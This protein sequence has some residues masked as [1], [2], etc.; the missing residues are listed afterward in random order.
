MYTH[1]YPLFSPWR[2]RFVAFFSNNRSVTISGRHCVA[3]RSISEYVL[4]VSFDH[5]ICRIGS[6]I[7]LQI[8]SNVVAPSNQ[9]GWRL[10]RP[11]KM[12]LLGVFL[13]MG[14]NDDI[15]FTSMRKSL[16][17]MECL[18]QTNIINSTIHEP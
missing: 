13:S 11:V 12:R 14:W 18:N 7:S 6:S 2:Q 8:K 16:R 3:F 9:S 15:Y 5:C 1:G 4:V 10:R 17:K